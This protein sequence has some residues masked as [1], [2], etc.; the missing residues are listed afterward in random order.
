ME[1]RTSCMVEQIAEALRTYGYKVNTKIG[2]SDFKID[3]G[4]IDPDTPERYRL[5][6]ICDGE[7]YYRLKTARDREIVRPAVLKMLGWKLMHVWSLEWFMRPEI[8]MK[9]ILKNL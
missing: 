8:V 5:G 4:V 6:I 3:L 9:N 2:S 7:E 1:S